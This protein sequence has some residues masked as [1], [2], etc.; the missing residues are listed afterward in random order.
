MSATRVANPFPVNSVCGTMTRCVSPEI[1]RARKDLRSR[2]SLFYMNLCLY[3]Y[4]R[5]IRMSVPDRAQ[6]MAKAPT[7]ITDAGILNT[8]NGIDINRKETFA[9]VC[10]S[11]RAYEADPVLARM[12]SAWVD[13]DNRAS[14][15]RGI[16]RW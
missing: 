16:F 12:L 5:L 7:Y 8:L 10:N 13:E 14:P 3:L 1:F 15:E 11:L 4:N 2:L 9:P 6:L